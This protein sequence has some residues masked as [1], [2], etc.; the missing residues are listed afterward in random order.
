[1]VK[2]SELSASFI[3]T[4]YFL[5]IAL[6]TK[7][8]SVLP[9]ISIL[10][11]RYC[12]IIWLLQFCS[13]PRTKASF[14]T[15][16]AIVCFQKRFLKHRIGIVHDVSSSELVSAPQNMLLSFRLSCGLVQCTQKGC[17]LCIGYDLPNFLRF[18]K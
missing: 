6:V 2:R 13:V 11:W 8:R 14:V 9:L 1:M 7:W 18:N 3:K 15:F 16:W 12:S 10:R 5:F 17:E 4:H